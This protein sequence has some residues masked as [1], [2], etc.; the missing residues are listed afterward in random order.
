MVDIL[1]SA[2]IEKN[3]LMHLLQFTPCHDTKL[4][5]QISFKNSKFHKKLWRNITKHAKKDQK[6]K[7]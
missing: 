4:K 3:C 7:S 1:K 6:R 5:S 2:V